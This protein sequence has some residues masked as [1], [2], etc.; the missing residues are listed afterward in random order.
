MK[1]TVQRHGGRSVMS[2]WNC[3]LCKVGNEQFAL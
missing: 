1:D 2:S 3:S